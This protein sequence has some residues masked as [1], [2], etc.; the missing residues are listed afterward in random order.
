MG[1][2]AGGIWLE[3]SPTVEETLYWLNLLIDTDLAI[4]GCAAQRPH[5]QLANDGDRNIVD[6]VDFI[7]SG[8]GASI[9]AVGV[10]DER[11]YAAREFKLDFTHFR[12]HERGESESG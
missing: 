5:G 9:G 12:R 7:L 4:A 1:D 3:G 10:Q 11:I 8:L 6:A 2:Y